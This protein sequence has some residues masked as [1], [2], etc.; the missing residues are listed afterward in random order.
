MRDP[1]RGRRLGRL[2]RHPDAYLAFDSEGSGTPQV[3]VSHSLL[4]LIIQVRSEG[5]YLKN[6]QFYDIYR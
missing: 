1:A 3:A 6:K 5:H 2:D 4:R